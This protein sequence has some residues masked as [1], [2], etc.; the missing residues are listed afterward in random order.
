MERMGGRKTKNLRA[1][2][3]DP[4]LTE[5]VYSFLPR[6]WAVKLGTLAKERKVAK[7]AIVRRAC[8]MYLQKL[9]NP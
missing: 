4:T 9:E 8:L 7:S 6:K 3:G 2:R 5:R 1:R